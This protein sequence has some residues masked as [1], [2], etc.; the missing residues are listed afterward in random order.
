MDRKRS[1]Q[2]LFWVFMGLLLAALPLA[3][4]FIL[5]S[6]PAPAPPAASPVALPNPVSAAELRIIQLE[7]TVEV[8]RGSGEWAQASSDQVLQP[9][10]A[11][12]TG[13]GSSAVLSAKDAYDV[14][15]ESGTDVSVDTLTESISRLM[16]G[17]GMATARVH[18]TARQSFEVRASGTETVARTS[19]GTFSITH[20]GQGT[21]A[22]GTREGS[23]EFSGRGKAVIVRAGQQSIARDGGAPSDP[24]PLPAS[25]LTKVQWPD[26]EHHRSRTL[27]IRGTTAPGAWVEVNGKGVQV[28][29]QGAF[30]Q[31]L[32]LRE[33][34]NE[35]TVRAKAVGGIVHHEQ[36]KVRVDTTP[37]SVGLD[38]DLWK[39]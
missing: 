3:Y 1:S 33:G 25:L 31:K 39:K 8:R 14:R 38:S 7:G 36:K 27:L 18:G 29:A 32:Q 9:A 20:N 22:L 12:R 19:S 4:V 35:V 37:P 28:D 5:D 13:E 30:S 21:V 10:D 34:S 15:L 11:V 6:D 26:G 17:R 23:V 24:V 16:L 2:V